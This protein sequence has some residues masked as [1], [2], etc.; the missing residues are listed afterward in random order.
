MI[1]RFIWK[2]YRYKDV[3]INR[4]IYVERGGDTGEKWEEEGGEKEKKR[5]DMHLRRVFRAHFCVSFSWNS[6]KCT[7]IFC[8]QNVGVKLHRLH[9]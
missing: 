8:K 2:T 3:L 6:F 4:Q 7:V 9:Y 1:V 5:K